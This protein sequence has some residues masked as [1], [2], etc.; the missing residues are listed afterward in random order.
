[1]TADTDVARSLRA[2]AQAGLE[3][4][5]GKLAA[6][7]DKLSQQ[8][9]RYVQWWQDLHPAPIL[10]A[11]LTGNPAAG[12]SIDQPDRLQPKDTYWWDVRRLSCWGFTAGSVNV[13]LNDPNGEQIA[14]FPQAGQWSWGGQLM[15]SPRDRLIAVVATNVTGSVFLAGQVI[16][17]A[18]TILPQYLD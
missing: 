11:A 7:V 12:A 13:F 16:E 2:E 9:E 5:L 6:A 17:V 15:L 8:E 4:T 10:T 18:G 1:M 14:S 3:L